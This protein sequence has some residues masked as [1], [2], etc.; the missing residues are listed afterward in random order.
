MRLFELSS[1]ADCLRFCD[2]RERVLA[3]A[4][5]RRLLG[6]ESEKT[7]KEILEEIEHLRDDLAHA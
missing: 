2:K 4:A 1:L 7:G 5:L 6:F 3:N